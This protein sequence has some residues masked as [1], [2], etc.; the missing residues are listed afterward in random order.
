ML[1]G[2]LL[3]LGAVLGQLDAARL[4]AP[5]DQDLG[6]DDHRVAELLGRLDGLGDG[7]R[8][9]S[10]G[11]GNAVLLEELLALIFEEVHENLECRAAAPRAQGPERRETYRTRLEPP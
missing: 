11:H 10:V 1:P 3:D 8:R 6:L 7:R 9:P 2:V 4:A 5:A